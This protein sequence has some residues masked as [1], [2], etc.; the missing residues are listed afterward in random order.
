MVDTNIR[1]VFIHEL[2]IAESTKPAELES[3]AI[4]VTPDGHANDWNNALMDYGALEATAA[5]TGIKPTS[6]QSRFA[7][8]KRQVRGNILKW[9]IAHGP[10]AISLLEKK[11]PHDTFDQI[12]A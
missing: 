9:I 5:K 1:R 11:C 6:K 7:G 12:V 2:N 10:T 4:L 3:L 8:S